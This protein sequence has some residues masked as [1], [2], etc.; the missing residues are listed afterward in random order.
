ML[1]KSLKSFLLDIEIK[2]VE[3]KIKNLTSNFYVI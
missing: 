2:V 1:R 3:P